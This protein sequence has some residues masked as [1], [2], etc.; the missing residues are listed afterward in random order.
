ME[1]RL[2]KL[3]N[4]NQGERKEKNQNLKD[5]LKYL[6][7]QV[8]SKICQGSLQVEVGHRFVYFGV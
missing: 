5:S 2:W 1:N 7:A 8:S 4:K 3:F 6:E